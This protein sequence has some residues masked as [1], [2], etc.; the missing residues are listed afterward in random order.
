[1]P[2]QTKR[3]SL[4]A[5][6][7]TALV[8]NGNR[9]TAVTILDQAAAFALSLDLGNN[10]IIGPIIGAGRLVI[11]SDVPSEDVSE[12]LALVNDTAQAGVIVSIVVAYQRGNAKDRGGISYQGV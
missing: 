8:P 11:D 3:V 7:R 6:G 2:V 1:M 10:Q 4:A 5:V 12:G 9:L